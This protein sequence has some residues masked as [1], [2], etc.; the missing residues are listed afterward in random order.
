M[1]KTNLQQGSPLAVKQSGFTLIELL[2]VIGIIAVLAAIVLIA[3]NP[4]RQFRLANDAERASEVNAILS[5]IGQYTVDQ[6]GTLP[7]DIPSGTEEDDAENISLDESNLCAALVP[8]Y[9]P[10][11]P[12]DPTTGDDPGD[13]R[14]DDQVSQPECDDDYDTGYTVMNNNGRVT[15][16][17]PATQEADETISVTR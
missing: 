2:V 11:L 10:A 3:I 17:A 7:G 1:K 4:A 12:I 16:F 14:D 13:D 5:A 8:Q 6:K 15:V 9:L